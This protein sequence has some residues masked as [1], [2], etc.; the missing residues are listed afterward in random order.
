MYR[1]FWHD[2]LHLQRPIT[3]Y[4]QEWADVQSP[5]FGILVGA[6]GAL[7]TFLSLKHPQPWTWALVAGSGLL[8]AHFFWGDFTFTKKGG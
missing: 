8:Y 7:L 6:W 2:V 5:L 1:W 3:R 4:V